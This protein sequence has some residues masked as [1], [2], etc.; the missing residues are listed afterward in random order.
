MSAVFPGQQPA[1]QG[2]AV[3]LLP[4]L[5]AAAL[6]AAGAASVVAAPLPAAPTA[7]VP[8]RLTLSR[9]FSSDSPER[10]LNRDE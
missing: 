7:P 6:A 8:D 1:A 4:V 2:R 3:R 5:A 9:C 10:T